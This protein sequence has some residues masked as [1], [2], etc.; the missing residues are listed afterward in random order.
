M[1]SLGSIKKE[2]AKMIKDKN[3]L[4]LVVEKANKIYGIGYVT[5]KK[6]KRIVY[7]GVMAGEVKEL[8]LKEEVRGQ[9][10]S[11]KMK[12]IFMAW[13][14]EKK[15]ELVR[16]EVLSANPASK[17]YANWGFTSYVETFAKKI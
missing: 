6:D 15:C 2:I 7:P 12:D 8:W 13:F 9:G 5:A 16:I 11:S 17:I 4:F 14:K 1:K 3:G 10:I